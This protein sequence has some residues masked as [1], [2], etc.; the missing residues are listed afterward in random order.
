[1]QIHMQRF[2]RAWFIDSLI[3]IFPLNRFFLWYLPGLV[4]CLFYPRKPEDFPGVRQPG[5]V[6]K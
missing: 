4:F 3:Y 5:R 1:M 2:I 6:Q